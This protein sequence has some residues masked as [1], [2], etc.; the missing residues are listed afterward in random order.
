MRAK[1][2]KMF[3]VVTV[4][5]FT[6]WLDI[7]PVKVNK[8][9]GGTRSLSPK[10]ATTIV[11]KTLQKKWNMLFRKDIAAQKKAILVLE[12]EIAEKTRSGDLEYMVEARRWLNEGYFEKYEYLID[13]F[14]DRSQYK[15]EDYF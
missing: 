8:S 11:G 4:D 2:D 14:K 9:R 7:Y 6:K 1:S 12:L 13:D 3:S 15:D 10:D 5:L